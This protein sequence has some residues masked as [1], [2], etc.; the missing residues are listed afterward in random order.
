MVNKSDHDLWLLCKQNDE[1]AFKELFYRYYH[2][3]T[4]VAIKIV[5]DEFEA[6]DIAQNV[7]VAIWNRRGEIKINSSI[8]SYLHRST[9]NKALNQIKKR[10]IDYTID[11]DIQI[12]SKRENADTKLE[13]NELREIIHQAINQL[14]DRCRTIFILNR[15]EHLSYK[16]IAERLEISPRTVEVQLAK[17]RKA[18]RDL[19]A[20][21]RFILFILMIIQ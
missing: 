6:K 18:L 14:P 20:A 5:Q 4:K 8:K 11:T 17:A 16:D 9:L 3:L 1:A 13:R 7:Y 21:H 2:Y 12:P 10:K 19:L 15:F